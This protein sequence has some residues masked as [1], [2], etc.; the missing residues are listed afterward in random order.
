MTFRLAP[1]MELEAR[2]R[3]CAV[4]KSIRMSTDKVEEV[5]MAV[6]EACI[7]AIEHSRAADGQLHLE[8]AVLGPAEAEEP[9]VLRIT[10]QDQGI[11]FDRSRV[12]QPR[13]EDNLKAIRKR[14]WGLKII[15]GLMDEVNVLSGE[16]GTSVVMSKAR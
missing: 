13:I 10:I 6:V 9:R 4:A 12:V 2:A 15:E 16:G 11:G 8:L 7:N 5:G 3:A 14:G 1:E